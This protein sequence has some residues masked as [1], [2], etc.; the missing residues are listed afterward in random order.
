M[1]TKN[2]SRL[3]VCLDTCHVFVAQSELAIE[4]GAFHNDVVAVS[5]ET[6][7]FAHLPDHATQVLQQVI[8]QPGAQPHVEL[9]L[10]GSPPSQKPSPRRYGRPM[11]V[12]TSSRDDTLMRA[13][14]L[15]R[16]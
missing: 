4:A 15:H 14:M 5:N 13:P 2:P 3:A 10:N 7:L 16:R 9:E 8:G 1:L 12:S 6:L 11:T